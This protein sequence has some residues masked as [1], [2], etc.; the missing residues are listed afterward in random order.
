[1]RQK[2]INFIV[3]NINSIGGVETVTETLAGE[4]FSRGSNVTIHSIYSRVTQKPGMTNYQIIHYSLPEPD[5]QD[6][7]FSKIKVVIKNG[8]NLFFNL[9]SIRDFCIFQG[10]YVGIYMPFL[11]KRTVV[12]IICEHNSHDA[13]SKLSRLARRILYRLCKPIVVV[14]SKPDKNYFDAIGVKSHVILNPVPRICSDNHQATRQHLQLISLGRFTGQKR[15][16]LMI[17]I[18]G[19]LLQTHSEWRLTLQ[20]DGEEHEKITKEIKNLKSQEQ[21]EILPL[22]D[23]RA[24]Y[25]RG[26]IFLMTSQFEG[27]P[28]SLIEAISFG[29]PVVAMNCSGGLAEII[30]NDQNG[31]LT[32]MDSEESFIEKVRLLMENENLWR[33]LSDGAK[34]SSL[35]FAPGAIISEWEKILK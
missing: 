19:K 32:P 21:I 24:L 28:M 11:T 8:L 1:M 27:L 12:K 35:K 26:S 17:R 7:V 5:M 33:R 13:P 34:K 29:L 20:G 14:L 9:R 22:G 31:Y 6:S 4:F 18:C 30:E 25:S 15:F 16:D 3:G 23:P 10:F 2:N